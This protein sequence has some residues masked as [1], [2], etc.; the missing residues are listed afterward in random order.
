VKISIVT[1]SYNQAEFLERAIRSVIEQNYD[2]IDY[3]VV[4]PGSTDG[5][6]EI[7]EK[8]RDRITKIIYEPDQGP[9]DGLNKG[10]AVATGDIFGYLNS[11]DA[12][13]PGAL[14]RVAKSFQRYEDAKVI[15]GHGYIVDRNGRVK[16]RFYSDRFTPW[17]FVHGGAVV[18]Q[19]ST[20]FRKDAFLTVKGFN[21]SNP[22]WWDAELL[23]DFAMLDMKMRVINDFWSVFTIHHQSISGQKGQNS[24]KSHKI[25]SDR[26]KTYERLYRK[27]TG[28]GPDYWTPF[29]MLIARIQKW[30]MQPVGSTWRV[31]EK[32]ELRIGKR[33]LNL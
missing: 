8:Y 26:K 29:F 28:H 18:M 20:F 16:R 27:V 15:Y 25:N 7:I 9:P 22:I 4:D 17:R 33:A 6:R 23:L 3:I 2:E 31:I 14:S 30:I 19:Q 11:D 24:I 21:Q 32:L 13:L 1:I 12:F 5:S 10:F